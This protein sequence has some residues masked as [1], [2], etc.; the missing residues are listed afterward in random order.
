MLQL[1][2]IGMVSLNTVVRQMN[3]GIRQVVERKF[4][5][6]RATHAVAIEEDMIMLV[7]EDPVANI[8]FA[9]LNKKGSIDVALQ[10]PTVRCRHSE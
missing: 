5:A 6:T 9:F 4:C 8:K 2:K 3:E 1:R 7:D 10:N